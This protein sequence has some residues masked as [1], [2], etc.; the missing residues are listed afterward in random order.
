MIPPNLSSSASVPH[1]GILSINATH[2][3]IREYLNRC[4]FKNSDIQ[5]EEEQEEIILDEKLDDLGCRFHII[6]KK[7]AQME[8]NSGNIAK[9]I[10]VY[11]HFGTIGWNDVKDHA[12][13]SLRSYFGDYNVTL[14]KTLDESDSTAS[15][16][17]EATI[18]DASIVVNSQQI[19]NGQTLS[20]CLDSLSKIH[21]LILGSRLLDALY[22]LSHEVDISD[23]ATRE[24]AV[25]TFTIPIQRQSNKMY[26]S[27]IV[28][29]TPSERVIVVIPVAFYIETDRALAKLF[30]Q[31]FHQ[32]QRKSSAKNAPICDF[33]RCN[34]PPREI[35]S[36]QEEIYIDDNNLVGY[37]SFTILSNQFNKEEAQM[38]VTENILMFVDFLDYHIKCSKSY[39]HTRM[40]EKKDVFLKELHK[41]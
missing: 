15:I 35:L 12:M 29:S 31:Q 9:G 4:N 1:D 18:Y 41:E 39:I 27:M 22:R 21:T 25:E 7:Y 20:S 28:T 19:P 5:L 34:D 26:H 38:K 14:Y 30:L 40:R 24:E 8:S 37:I 6:V 36:M 17:S 13:N 23:K 16:S 32:A 2:P 33:R 11:L 3:K 10:M